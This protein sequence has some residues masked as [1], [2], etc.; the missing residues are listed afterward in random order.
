METIKPTKENIQELETQIREWEFFLNSTIGI[1]GFT[2][3]LACLGTNSPSLNGF[4][5][6]VFLSCVYKLGLKHFPPMLKELR[7]RSERR[8]AQED[9]FYL[10]SMKR[11]F[12][13]KRAILN[14]PLFVSGY[15]FLAFVIF[16]H[17]ILD[18]VDRNRILEKSLY[19]QQSLNIV[20][21][22]QNTSILSPE[23]NL[24]N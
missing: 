8:D 14:N 23:R 16:F 11:Y 10:G 17:Q 18:Q 20:S 21:Q 7:N 19:G 15:L 2:F 6:L 24:L 12:S 22:I 9:I 4:L 13:L 5:S 1:L 3:A